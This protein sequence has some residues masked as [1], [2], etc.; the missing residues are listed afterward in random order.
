MSIETERIVKCC[1]CRHTHNESER[2]MSVEQLN[3][4]EV[5]HA[6]AVR[7]VQALA[8]LAH[9]G[10]GLRV[11]DEQIDEFRLENKREVKAFL[12]G[13]FGASGLF[14]D[15]PFCTGSRLAGDEVPAKSDQ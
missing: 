3:S 5:W 8:D 2:V 10:L 9:V 1:R 14:L 7:N 11:D 12:L 13:V 4:V 15:P 6:D